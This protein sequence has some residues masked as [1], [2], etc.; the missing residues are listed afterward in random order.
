MSFFRTWF[1]KN[2][3]GLDDESVTNAVMIMPFG[4]TYPKYR[5]DRN[6]RVLSILHKSAASTDGNEASEFCRTVFSVLFTRG[7]AASC[8]YCAE[9]VIVS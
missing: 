8:A 7:A 5:D 6:E 4:S 9:S 2:I 3:L 1:E